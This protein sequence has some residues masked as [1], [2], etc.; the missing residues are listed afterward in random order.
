V[1]HEGIPLCEHAN[2]NK[3]LNYPYYRKRCFPKYHCRRL[4]ADPVKRMYWN[5]HI[6]DEVKMLF[7]WNLKSLLFLFLQPHKVGINNWDFYLITTFQQA[8]I[9]PIQIYIQTKNLSTEKYFVLKKY[10]KKKI[11]LFS[12]FKTKTV[13]YFFRSNRGKMKFEYKRR[14]CL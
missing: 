11:F 10:P 3:E 8:K 12:L 9:K 4:T 1:V 7:H 6:K 2:N 5:Q 14:T 13:L